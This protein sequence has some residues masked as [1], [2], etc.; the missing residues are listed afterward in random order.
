MVGVIVQ[1]QLDSLE[2][3]LPRSEMRRW[4]AKGVVKVDFVQILPAKDLPEQRV[5]Q[6]DGIVAKITG[7]QDVSEK[8]LEDKHDGAMDVIGVD[9]ADANIDTVSAQGEF[10][11]DVD[12]QRHQATANRPWQEMAS[13]L[14]GACIISIVGTKGKHN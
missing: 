9:Q 4:I 11:N 5:V 1:E 14:G 7:V 2:D 8:S 12:L 13:D 3:F 6:H 10:V